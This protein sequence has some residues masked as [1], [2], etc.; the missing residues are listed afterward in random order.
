VPQCAVI[1][2]CLRCY[3]DETIDAAAAAAAGGG[4]YVVD[5]L[6][7]DGAD[8]ITDCQFLIVCRF[9]VCNYNIAWA[10]F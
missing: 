2:A 5:G 3:W 8:Y 10:L 4:R 6:C 1:D 9:A 7:A